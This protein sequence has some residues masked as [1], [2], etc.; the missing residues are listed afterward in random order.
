MT[1][2]QSS[3]EV[4]L[5]RASVHTTTVFIVSASMVGVCLTAASLIRIVER[6]GTLRVLSR[7]VLAIDSLVFLA[8]ALVSLVVSR[9]IVGGHRS[10][11]LPV[12]EGAVFLGLVGVVVVC[13]TLALTLL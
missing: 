11:L 6:G 3:D 2:V 8:G 5:G 13:I 12:A 10:P 7:S 9:T 4:R 1:I